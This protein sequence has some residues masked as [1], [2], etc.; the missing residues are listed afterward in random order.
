MHESLRPAG[1]GAGKAQNPKLLAMAEM[2]LKTSTQPWE[3]KSGQC[4]RP[5]KG[6]DNCD[7]PPLL[8]LQHRI[9][10]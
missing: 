3:T 10:Q 6:R 5:L 1:T 2:S 4:A 9:S 8:E 7:D